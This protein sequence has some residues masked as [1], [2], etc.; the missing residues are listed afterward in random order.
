MN[1]QMNVQMNVHKTHNVIDGYLLEE[2]IRLQVSL[3][4][5]VIHNISS[6]DGIKKYFNDNTLN[7]VDNYIQFSNF[8]VLIQD[9]WVAKPTSQSQ[10]AQFL[11]CVDK[12]TEKLGNNFFLIW[13][14]KTP[15]SRNAIPDLNRKKV[16]II[17][18]DVSVDELAMSV[19]DYIKELVDA[20]RDVMEIDD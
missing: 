19:K 4:P 5:G 14:C 6:D 15:P 10:A 16:K 3:L 1:V 20:Q 8:Y 12:I 17:C 7:G 11:Q 2:K 18:S 9:K 13:A